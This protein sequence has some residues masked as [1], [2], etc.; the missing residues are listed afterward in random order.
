[1]LTGLCGFLTKKTLLENRE[2]S[3]ILIMI[4]YFTS[5][6]CQQG[7]TVS[8]LFI[9]CL[10]QATEEIQFK[11]GSTTD[12]TAQTGEESRWK[13]GEGEENTCQG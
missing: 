13:H 3:Q 6:L 1:M 11:Q 5:D 10:M 7:H 8:G 4:E 2:N 12:S 9:L